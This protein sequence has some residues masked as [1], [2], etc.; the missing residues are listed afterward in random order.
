MSS[1]NCCFLTCIH[2]SQEVSQVVWYSHIFQNF[3]QFIVIHTVKG[4]PSL[5][6]WPQPL[7]SAMVH[8]LKSGFSL[9][10]N[11]FTSY[12][13]VSPMRH[14]S[15]SFISFGRAWVLGESW[16][17]GGKSSG[18]NVPRYP[19]HSP[20]ENL[21]N[22][23]PMLTVPLVW[24]LAQRREKTEEPAPAWVTATGAQQIVPLGHAEE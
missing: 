14:Q 8:T 12:R 10:P 19:L 22:I 18:K 7:L 9:D 15:L 21:R 1:S 3:P 17:T 24:S 16:R 5:I 20:P 11:K 23:W 6:P 13:F 4:S 2:I